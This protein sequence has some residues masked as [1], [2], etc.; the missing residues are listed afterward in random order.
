M[1]N[2]RRLAS[3]QTSAAKMFRRHRSS[4]MRGS[5]MVQPSKFNSVL[6]ATVFGAYG[7]T[8]RYIMEEIGRSDL[9]Y[10]LGDDKF[11]QC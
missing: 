6:T 2:I 7:S 1:Q 11:I 9:C 3:P 4:L 8:G 10:F 5:Y